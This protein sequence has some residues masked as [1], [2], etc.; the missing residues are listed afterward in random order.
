MHGEIFTYTSLNLESA[1]CNLG[2]C[3]KY[4]LDG[5]HFL[6]KSVPVCLRVSSMR[7]CMCLC[8]HVHVH[9]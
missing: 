8:V 5:E 4:F 3:M 2:A 6:K 9:R 1:L 7:T